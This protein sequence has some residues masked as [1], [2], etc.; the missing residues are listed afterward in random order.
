MFHY[1]RGAEN[2]LKES[3]NYIAVM[4]YPGIGNKAGG[5]RVDYTLNKSYAAN[6][7]PCWCVIKPPQNVRLNERKY[8][9]AGFVFGDRDTNLPLFD[10]YAWQAT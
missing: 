2:E 10:E 7:Y 9:P 3:S 8:L 4:P 5:L 6:S 1:A